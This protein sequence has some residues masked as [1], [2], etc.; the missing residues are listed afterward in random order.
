MGVY[1]CTEGRGV[2]KMYDDE[3]LTERHSRSSI[4]ELLKDNKQVFRMLRT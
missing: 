1:D 3:V 4:T 2:F